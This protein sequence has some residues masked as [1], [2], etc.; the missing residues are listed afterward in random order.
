MGT[1][2]VTLS[3]QEC[4]D[5]LAATTVGRVAFCTSQGPRIYPVNFGVVDGSVVFRTAPYSDLGT[6]V[7]GA[8]VAFEVDELRP[9]EE[10]GWSVVVQG[11]A[12]RVEDS[13]EMTQLRRTI[14]EPW[15]SGQRGMFVRVDPTRMSGRSV[16]SGR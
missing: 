6:L 16:G 13:G 7:V 8:Q 4:R 2:F 12:I 11:R 1:S 5:R 9:D 10:V 3:T 14:P 15:A